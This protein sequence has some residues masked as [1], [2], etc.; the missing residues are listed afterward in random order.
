MLIKG[1][2]SG[3]LECPLYTCLPVYPNS[4]QYNKTVNNKDFFY[5]CC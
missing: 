2:F 1:K 4:V 5:L 3:S